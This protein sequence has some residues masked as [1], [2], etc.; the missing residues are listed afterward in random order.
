MSEKLHF[1]DTSEFATYPNVDVAFN[2][3]LYGTNMSSAVVTVDGSKV[4]GDESLIDFPEQ[5]IERYGFDEVKRAIDDKLHSPARSSLE[6]V[7]RIAD[8]L[9]LINQLSDSWYNAIAKAYV[10]DRDDQI[11]YYSALQSTLDQ[12]T[13]SKNLTKDATVPSLETSIEYSIAHLTD[14]YLERLR[15]GRLDSTYKASYAKQ[16]SLLNNIHAMAQQIGHENAERTS[17]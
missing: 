5:A 9:R 4:Y 7:V 2:E 1:V 15:A 12:L 17:A 14:N 3:R 13:P 10:E 16:V 11:T 8:N 6:S